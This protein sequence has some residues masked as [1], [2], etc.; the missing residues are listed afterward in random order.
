M[1]SHKTSLPHADRS[2][3]S[4][5]IAGS[6]FEICVGYEMKSFFHHVLDSFDRPDGHRERGHA[7]LGGF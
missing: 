2:Q 4:T 3:I 7:A 6:A 5:V 1:A